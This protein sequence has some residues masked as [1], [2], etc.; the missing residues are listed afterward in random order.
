MFSKVKSLGGR[1]SIVRLVLPDF[2]FSSCMARTASAS[3][4]LAFN[5]FN[6]VEEDLLGAFGSSDMLAY[7]LSKLCMYI[8][9]MNNIN[10]VKM[11]F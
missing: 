9:Y 2:L 5:D 10:I 6:G 1:R 4:N 7:I 11:I 8:L 3:A